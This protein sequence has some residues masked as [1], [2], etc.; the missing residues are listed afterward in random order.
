LLFGSLFVSVCLLAFAWPAAGVFAYMADYI[1]APVNYWWGEALVAYGVRFSFFLAIAIGGGLLL[2]W[3]KLR[4]FLPGP[5]FYSQEWL[6][7][8]FVAIVLL[9]RLWGMPIDMAARD[10]SGISQTPAE[11][12]VKVAI[13]V[14]MMTHVLTRAK[15]M[16]AAYWF[17]IL[18]GGLLLGLDAY[19]ASE[20]RFVHGRLDQLGGAD[21][22]ESSTV[23]A[24]LAF[25][26]ALAGA[27]FLKSREW[28]KKLICMVAGAFTVNALI[29]TQT[30]AAMLGLL[31][32]GLAAP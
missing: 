19:M 16:D 22:R 31:A 32:G 23:G 14:L 26:G 2:N 20:S 21:Y 6:V 27:V 4:Q 11:K 7:V 15:E 1:I 25:V 29:L 5:I 24:H 13:F 9:S 17:L 28:W 10:L 30:R 12:M 18:V 3:S 8:F